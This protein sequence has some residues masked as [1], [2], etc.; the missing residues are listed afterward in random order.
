MKTWFRHLTKRLASIGALPDED[1]ETRLPKTT[2]VLTSILF[3]FAGLL[4]GCMYVYFGEG[5]AA[6]I[7]LGYAFFSMFSLV[8]YGLTKKFERYRFAQLFLIL[9]LP[10]ALMVALGG[11]VEGLR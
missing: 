1:A 8:R 2:L 7:P 6:L 9:L 10:F 3:M 4:W 11:F 5:L